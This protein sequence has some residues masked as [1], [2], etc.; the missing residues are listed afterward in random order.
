MKKILVLSG[1]GS[2]ISYLAGV[3]S[4]LDFVP[5]L[6]IGSSAGAIIGLAYSKGINMLEAKE[7]FKKINLFNAY[8][9]MRSTLL[10]DSKPVIEIIA[11]VSLIDN[12]GIYSTQFYS[13]PYDI[14]LSANHPLITKWKYMKY[15]E[16]C[17]L[18]GGAVS[19]LPIA[20]IFRYASKDD[21]LYLVTTQKIK[22]F[23]VSNRLQA[24]TTYSTLNKSSNKI[25]EDLD[26]LYKS[27]YNIKRIIE[28]N[29]KLAPV[30]Y[31]STK[32]VNN[33]FKIGKESC[34]DI[35]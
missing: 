9:V 30:W 19:N 5:D 6:I 26:L 28:P 13:H 4:Q 29:K 21:E 2:K 27:Q 12:K 16:G 20:A 8:K 14:M 23:N 22:R 17:Y 10:T 24:F 33:N 35:T 32:V 11:Q 3:I 7:E 15:P 25:L 31:N 34:L 1:G 18:D